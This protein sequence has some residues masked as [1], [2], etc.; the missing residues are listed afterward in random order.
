MLFSP[1]ILSLSNNKYTKKTLHKPFKSFILPKFMQLNDYIKSIKQEDNPCILYHAYCAD[2]LCSAV[3][4]KKAIEKILKIKINNIIAY[5]SYEITEEIIRYFEEKNI[6]KAIFTDISLDVYPEMVKKAEKNT[7]LL[8]IDHHLFNDN[9]NSEKTTFIHAS[10]IKPE[11]DSSEYPASKL[12]YD[13]FSEITDIKE[14]NWISVIGLISDMGYKT[15]KEFCHATL[16]EYKVKIE[17][18]KIFRTRIGKAKGT[19]STALMF[20]NVETEK[21]FKIIEEAE[22]FEDIIKNEYLKSLQKKASEEINKYIELRN[23]S[24][25]YNGLI[26]YEIK[27][28]IRLSSTLST[29]LSMEYFNK[30]TLIIITEIPGSDTLIISA[31]DQTRK[32]NLNEFLKEATKN[33][34]NSTAGGHIPAAG[35]KIKKEHLETF[36]EN[37]KKLYKP[38]SNNN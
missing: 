34:P 30:N 26:I 32:I 14:T 22:N 31:R 17:D 6:K 33:I 23:K 5:T 20:Q 10:L 29:I 35:A 18:N 27:S 4:I 9:L 12:V 7:E 8:I 25:N 24:K 38:Y 36:K 19:L 21:I 15:W 1:I 11:I 37:I 3:I 13:L 2:G 16:K 28:S